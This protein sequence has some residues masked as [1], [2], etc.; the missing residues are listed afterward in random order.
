MIRLPRKK[1]AAVLLILLAAALILGIV[2]YLI[3]KYSPY[4]DADA[5]QSRQYSTRIYDKD[6][7][8]VQILPL[9][10]GLR[11][12]YTP[13][14]KIPEEVVKSFITAEDGRFHS[15][16]GI[17][18]AAIMRAVFQNFTGK[19]IV[20]GASTITMQLA[21]IITPAADRNFAAKLREA[22]NAL[23]LECRLR[24]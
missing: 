1:H 20:S 10:D 5:F 14:E 12:E 2:L 19:R 15:H 8:L 3:L 24:P 18:F 4:P 13:L 22:F 7:T 11:R 16:H 21:R 23:R 9:E 17:D 6:G